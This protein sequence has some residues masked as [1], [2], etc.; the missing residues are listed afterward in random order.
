L[1]ALGCPI[2]VG[3]S[4]KSM[5]GAMTGRAVAAGAGM[6]NDVYAL[7]QTGAP[8]A[9]AQLGVPVCLMH[10]QGEPRT[11]Q[12]QPDYRDVVS[13][14]RGFLQ[15]R[16][17]ACLRAGIPKQRILI[18]PGFGFGKLL[19][20]NLTLLRD[21]R[22]LRALGCPILVGIS[23]KSMLGAMTGRA[24]AD[25]Q[26]ASVAAA[27]LAI[28]RGAD[29]VRVHDVGPTVDALKVLRAVE[30]DPPGLAE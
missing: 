14:V 26:A 7:R 16:I 13:E 12:A 27:V 2:L 15:Q 11:M 20:H 3:I 18:D 23:R 10:M 21:L 25:R 17:D 22:S 28:Q 4:R 29:I 8:E 19:E 1:R 30:G 24:V 5:L 9:A 6:I